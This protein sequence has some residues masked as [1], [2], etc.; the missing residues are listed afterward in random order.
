[1]LLNSYSEETED[2][3]ETLIFIEQTIFEWHIIKDTQII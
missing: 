2:I 3:S 1:M